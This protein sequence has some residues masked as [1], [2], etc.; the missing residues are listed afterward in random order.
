MK[1]ILKL[2]QILIMY[3]TRKKFKSIKRLAN[4]VRP[5]SKNVVDFIQ[6]MKYHLVLE[7]DG[8]VFLG[9]G[10]KEEEKREKE[11]NTNDPNPYSIPFRELGENEKTLNITYLRSKDKRHGNSGDLFD[12]ENKTGEGKDGFQNT[13]A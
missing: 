10:F 13:A 1:K 2:I 7:S 4:L 9:D 8:K 5:E 6:E 3:R 11:E 12:P